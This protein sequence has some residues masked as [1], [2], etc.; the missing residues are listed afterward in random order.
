MIE[1]EE[2]D[3]RP[4]R[5][6]PTSISGRLLDRRGRPAPKYVVVIFAA[7][8]TQWSAEQDRVKHTR[9]SSNGQYVVS[10]L[11]AGDYFVGAVTDLEPD[12]LGDAG[13]L[14][15]LS[16]SATR[17]TLDAGSKRTLDLQIGGRLTRFAPQTADLQVRRLAIERPSDPGFAS[18][19]PRATRESRHSTADEG[20][21][22]RTTFRVRRRSRRPSGIRPR[23]VPRS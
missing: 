17:V 10:G 8:R 5:D 15:M 9:P 11:P 18:A 20:T 12:D 23:E 6:L 19:P 1:E 7:D 3:P 2:P 16:K 14:K 21:P 22:G 4:F 13:F